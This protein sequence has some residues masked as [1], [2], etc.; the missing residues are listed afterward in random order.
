MLIHVSVLWDSQ[1]AWG[2]DK[3]LGSL[4]IVA[5]FGPRSYS[6]G[7]SSGSQLAVGTAG[8]VAM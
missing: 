6:C 3:T 5:G 1:V 7:H 4:E 8:A 2:H